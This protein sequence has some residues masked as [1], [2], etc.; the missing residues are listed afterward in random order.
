MEELKKNFSSSTLPK[1]EELILQAKKLDKEVP[2]HML[3]YVNEEGYMEKAPGPN[4]YIR[5]W[6]G[7]FANRKQF[8]GQEELIDWL[9]KERDKEMGHLRET[10]DPSFQRYYRLLLGVISGELKEASEE[11]EE[12][13]E[14]LAMRELIIRD[15]LEEAMEELSKAFQGKEEFEQ[16]DSELVLHQ[17]R[18]Y[19]LMTRRRE[20][21]ISDE[22][23]SREKAQI[24]KAIL[25]LLKLL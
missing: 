18:F 24:R 3:I 19:E 14:L 16:E 9:K 11:E 10:A 2:P 20:N 8:Y 17:A 25:H 23:Y 4:G 12:E 13:A 5:Q 22:D 7:E 6:M 15:Q 1:L 21:A